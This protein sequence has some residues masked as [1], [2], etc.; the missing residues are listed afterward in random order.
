MKIYKILTLVLTVFILFGLLPRQSAQPKAVLKE[1]IIAARS[2]SLDNRYNNSFVNSVFKDNILLTLRYLNG[3][4]SK[5]TVIN[6]KKVDEPFNFN[7]KLIPDSTF[8]FHDGVLP[9]FQG[10]VSK[11]TNAHFNSDE[12]FKSDGYLIGDGVCHLA[13]L[14]NWAAKDAGLYVVAPTSHD[15]AVIPEVPKKY[16]VS[17]FSQPVPSQTTLLQNLYIKNNFKK[18]ILIKFSYDG[19]NLKVAIVKEA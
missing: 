19:T 12:G 11:T 5:G 8:A 18:P 15:F 2:M 6:W 10:K 7:L 16:G 4:I 1:Q 13:S 14:I 9:E 17:I 3:D